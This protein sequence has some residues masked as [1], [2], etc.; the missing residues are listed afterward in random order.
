[1]ILTKKQVEAF[2]NRAGFDIDK[3]RLTLAAMRYRINKY[4]KQLTN[5][6]NPTYQPSDEVHLL[7]LVMCEEI[8]LRAFMD[9]VE[10]G[11]IVFIDRRKKVKQ[12][13][14]NVS[15]FYQMTRLI[16]ETSAKLGISAMDRKKL[17][18]ETQP[19]DGMKD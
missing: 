18:I 8:Q 12:K 17:S 11:T 10:N 5:Q 15:T 3:N 4:K 7:T 14:H 19:S 9:I 16:N 13:N 1:M 2:F 6:E